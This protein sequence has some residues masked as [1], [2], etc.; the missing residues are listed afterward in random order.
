M[1]TEVIIL[2][3]HGRFAQLTL[4]SVKV[5]DCLWEHTALTQ[6]LESQLFFAL[7]S[8]LTQLCMEVERPLMPR[9]QGGWC[10]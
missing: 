4:K 9:H 6:D 10:R 7:S 1:T 3:F 2:V 5:L 8:V